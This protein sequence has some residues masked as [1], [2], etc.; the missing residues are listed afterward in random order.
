ML[1]LST[2]VDIHEDELYKVS[3]SSTE[4][5]VSSVLETQD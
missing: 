2:S 5:Y 4:L 1:I 3:A